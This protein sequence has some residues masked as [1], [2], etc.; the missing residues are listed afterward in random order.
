[1]PV[2]LVLGTLDFKGHR[3]LNVC[4]YHSDWWRMR[5]V[6]QVAQGHGCGHISHLGEAKLHTFT[7]AS[8]KR[9]ALLE[10]GW[11]WP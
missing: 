9:L 2:H 8:S 1:M 11:G 5:A 6:L 3:S 10:C 7:L 4:V